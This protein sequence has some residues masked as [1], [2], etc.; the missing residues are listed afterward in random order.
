MLTPSDGL[1]FQ[2]LD[3]HQTSG[4]LAQHFDPN[5]AD[6]GLRVTEKQEPSFLVGLDHRWSDT[7][8]TLLLVSHF[9]DS[10]SFTDPH[11]GTLLL[12]QDQGNL[13]NFVQTDLTET[14][15]NRLTVDSFELQHLARFGPFQ[16]IAGTRFQFGND[17]LANDQSY[18]FGNAQ[19]VDSQGNRNFWDFFFDRGDGIPLVTNQSFRVN[20]ERITPYLYEYWRV[21][22]PLWLLG[23]VA[24]D[25]QS[26]PQNALFAPVDDGV[27]IERQ[28]SPKA[29]LI[30]TPNRWSVVRAAYS[31]SLGGASLDQSVRLEPTQLAGFA[32][33]YRNLIPESLVGGRGRGVV[34]EGTGSGHKMEGRSTQVARRMVGVRGKVSA[35]RAS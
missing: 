24:Y 29:G 18:F 14:F 26:L 31:Q 7:Q 10:L 1:F 21:A 30:W 13:L 34:G 12:T 8:R 11:G 3:F 9:N 5:Q 2:I 19:S 27:R 32:Q 16:T 20:S 25:Y 17:R 35:A 4:D 6:T 33:A 22:D 23:G 15:K 28:V